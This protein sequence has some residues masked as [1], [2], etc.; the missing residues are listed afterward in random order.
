MED[1]YLEPDGNVRRPSVEPAFYRYLREDV[2][3]GREIPI[4]V[5]YNDTH[6]ELHPAEGVPIDSIAVPPGVLDRFGEVAPGDGTV[7]LARPRS[8]YRIEQ[9]RAYSGFSHV[10]PN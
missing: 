6:F 1:V 4:T 10:D 9:M 8:S 5:K 7:L 3:G 2:Y